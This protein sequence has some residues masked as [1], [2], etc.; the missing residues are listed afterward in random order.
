[1]YGLIFRLLPGPK[2]LKVI[3]AVILIAAVF[4]L[5]FEFVFPWVND[6]FF[7]STVG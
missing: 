5:L 7:D 3:W 1:M 4:F 6:E 2:W